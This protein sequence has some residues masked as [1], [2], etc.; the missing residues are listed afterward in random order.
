MERRECE[1][2]DLRLN[3]RIEVRGPEKGRHS[4]LILSLLT[5]NVCSGGAFFTTEQ[6]LPK[7]TEVQVDLILAL[8]ALKKSDG[9]RAHINVNGTVL[10]SDPAGLAVRFDKGYRITP[11]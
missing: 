9:D 7:G 8:E 2:F 3:S 10:R 1:R 4:G 6:V 5:E 11:I